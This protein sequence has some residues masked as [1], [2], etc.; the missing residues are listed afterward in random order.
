MHLFE[1]IDNFPEY[2]NTR[3]EIEFV[4][5]TRDEFCDVNVK[6]VLK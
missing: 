4:E 1:K 6:A 3:K 5:D 2:M